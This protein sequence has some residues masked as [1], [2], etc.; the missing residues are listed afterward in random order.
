MN[1]FD[2]FL[3]HDLF[4]MVLRVGHAMCQLVKME[5]IVI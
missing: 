4:E 2:T 3:E 5:Q 1:I